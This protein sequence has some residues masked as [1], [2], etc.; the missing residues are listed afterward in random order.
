MKI[1]ILSLIEQK[2]LNN[3][4]EKNM[5]FQGQKCFSFRTKCICGIIINWKGVDKTYKL[6][7]IGAVSGTL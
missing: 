6:K 5:I 4:A 3:P 2:Q 7:N 1:E